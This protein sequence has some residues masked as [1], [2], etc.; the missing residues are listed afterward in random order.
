MT[1]QQIK[2]F[3]DSH[4]NL[5]LTELAQITGLPVRKL[6]TILLEDR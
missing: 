2:D 1:V 6:K 4:P 3:Y 5:L